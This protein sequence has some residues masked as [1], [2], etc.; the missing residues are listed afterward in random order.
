MENILKKIINRKKEKIIEYKKN[1]STE[2]IFENIK[3]FKSYIDFKA[4]L[5]ERDIGGEL[6][7]IAEIKKAS[8]SAGILRNNFNHIDIA[9]SYI[10]NGAPFLSILTEEDFF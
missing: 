2:Q 5:K 8:P 7:I 4:K 3:N 9:K 6:S 1:Y 10:E